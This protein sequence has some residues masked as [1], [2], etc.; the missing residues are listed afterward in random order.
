MSHHV[1]AFAGLRDVFKCIKCFA[2]ADSIEKTNENNIAVVQGF[3]VLTLV[4]KCDVDCRLI[5]PHAFRNI[6]LVTH[7]Y[8]NVVGFAGFISY[9]QVKTH[10][11]CFNAGCYSVLR[12]Q[13]GNLSM[14]NI[15]SSAMVKSSKL[16]AIGTSVFIIGADSIKIGEKT[17]APDSTREK[18]YRTSQNPFADFEPFS[19]IMLREC[20]ADPH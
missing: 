15:K 18:N 3:V 10:R 2:F 7:L 6:V 20:P 12:R 9:E 4:Q 16:F 8:F 14:Q 11:F 13:V 1:R 19:N 5:L 17:L